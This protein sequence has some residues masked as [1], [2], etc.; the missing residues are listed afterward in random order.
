MTQYTISSS[1]AESAGRL[2]SAS[3]ALRVGRA[4]VLSEEVSR[5]LGSNAC[6]SAGDGMLGAGQWGR[7]DV[8]AAD[9][10]CAVGTV[11]AIAVAIGRMYIASSNRKRADMRLAWKPLQT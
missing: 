3:S 11:T 7:W 6:Y 5:L 9:N 1:T 2:D 4:V 8:V 10:L